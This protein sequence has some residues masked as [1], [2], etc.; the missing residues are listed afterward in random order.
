MQSCVFF[1]D[2]YSVITM[3]FFFFNDVPFPCLFELWPTFEMLRETVDLTS[4]R[5]HQ[6]HG[7][8]QACESPWLQILTKTCYCISL[9]FCQADKQ[10]MVLCSHFNGKRQLQKGTQKQYVHCLEGE[11]E[12]LPLNRDPQEISLGIGSESVSQGP[13]LLQALSERILS[14]AHP[15]VGYPLL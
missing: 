10:I 6:S 8:H 7:R 14:S 2:G 3:I 12:K 9:I 4:K 13:G 1:P 5:F 15:W 11:A